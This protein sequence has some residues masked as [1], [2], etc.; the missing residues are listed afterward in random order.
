MKEELGKKIMTKF[1]GLTAKIYSYLIDD[2]SADKQAKDTKKCVISRKL[3]FENYKNCLEATQL[4]NKTNHLEK[5]K[6]DIGRVKENH[7]EFIKNNKLILKTQQRHKTERHNVF[8]EEINKIALNP[9]DYK[10]M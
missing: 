1:V 8:T 10:R 3:K 5:N 7:K 2:G 9:N 4:E 6:I